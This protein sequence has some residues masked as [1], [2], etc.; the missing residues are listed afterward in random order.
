M[1]Y[2]SESIEPYGMKGTIETK[3]I[4]SYET[5]NETIGEGEPLPS[6]QPSSPSDDGS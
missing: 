3:K 5:F 6:S 1:R 4:P 2:I